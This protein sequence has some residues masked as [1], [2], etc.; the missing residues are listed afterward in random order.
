MDVII[1]IF[2]N[3]VEF[4]Y[5][6]TGDYGIAIV[7][8]TITVKI[9][10]LPFSI[11]QRVAMKKQIT[12][13]KKIEDVKVKYKNNK[14]K[15]ENELNKLYMENSK[16]LLGCLLPI[17]QLPIIS[18]LYMSIN[19]LQLEAMSILVPW[20]INIGNTDDKFLVPIIYTLVSIAPSILS[21]LKV[22]D[23]D[24]KPATIKSILPMMV[25][26]V[27]IT[28]KSPIALGIYFITSGMFSLIEDI[29]FRIYSKN[30]VFSY[31]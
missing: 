26:G 18:G 16:G 8:L 17:L 11:K 21:Y 4:F 9:I 6:F 3:I 23:K 28:V 24:E 14:K 12:F 15:Q 13:T 30:K 31:K 7:L 20:A 1:N 27:L 29:V 25:M 5:N 2:K 22:F 19:R 10:L